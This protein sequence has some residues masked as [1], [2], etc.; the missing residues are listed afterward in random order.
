MR[1]I[2]NNEVK[3]KMRPQLM[4]S[5]LAALISVNR[6]VCIEGP[7]GGGKTTIVADVTRQL[8]RQYIE[9]HMPT[10]LVEDFGIPY[11]GAD[12]L[13]YK[14]PDWFPAKGSQ[15]DTGQG[16]VL[17]FDDRNQASADLQKVLANIC[18]A[19]NLHGVPMADG[20][21]VVSTGNRQSDRAGANRVLGHL[22]NR[23]TVLELET[24][25]Q[26][27]T[28]WMD[29]H[30]VDPV[31]V[32][33]LRLRP[34]LLHDYDPQRDSNPTPRS[35]VEGVSAV[36]GVVPAEAEFECFKGAVGEGAAAEFV[37]FLR[38]HRKLPS[39]DTILQ[40]PDTAPVPTD[41]ATLYAISGTLI[42]HANASTFGAICT[43]CERMPPEFSVLTVTAACRRTNALTHTP[44]FI[45]W[46]VKHQH[47]MF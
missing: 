34:N 16:G 30:G 3:N 33:F 1:P 36:L 9:R 45:Q 11:L 31:V 6:T 10:M 44:A 39:I 17:C 12:T 40:N 15:H 35:W 37:G 14:I 4:Q 7:P 29:T 26:D 13:T 46:S 18:Q 24:H 5:T 21:S 43:Y 19:R 25:L 8:G 42:A 32:S 27:S 22:R 23:E 38:I 28:A 41:P 20:W 2:S 47:V